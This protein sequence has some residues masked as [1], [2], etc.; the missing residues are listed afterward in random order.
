MFIH[1]GVST[2]RK[3][4]RWASLSQMKLINEGFFFRFLHSRVT[5]LCW[6]ARRVPGSV[7]KFESS[8]Q[9]DDKSRRTKPKGLE[10]IAENPR[11]K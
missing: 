10:V 5:D 9:V 7:F 8:P 2:Q 4:A 6:V 1:G 3:L 11:S